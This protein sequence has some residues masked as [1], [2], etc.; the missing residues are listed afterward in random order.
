MNLRKIEARLAAEAFYEAV[1]RRIAM[2]FPTQDAMEKYLKEHP[3]ADKSRHHVKTNKAGPAIAD[4]SI[5]DSIESVMQEAEKSYQ[6]EEDKVNEATS[7]IKEHTSDIIASVPDFPMD[8][9]KILT[10]PLGTAVDDDDDTS[11]DDDDEETDE[12]ETKTKEKKP[13]EPEE[14]KKKRL[15]AA[16]KV[17]EHVSAIIKDKPFVQTIADRYSLKPSVVV[18]AI[19]G[20]YATGGGSDTRVDLDLRLQNKAKKVMRDRI[21][22]ESRE[23]GIIPEKLLAF[24]PKHLGFKID[25][26]HHT[27][28]VEHFGN[29]KKT[30]L[31]KIEESRLVLLHRN[32]IMSRVAEDLKSP[33]E[34]TRMTAFIVRMGVMTG[35]R[36]GTKGNKVTHTDRETGKKTTEQTYGATTLR[37]KHI[38]AMK[39]GIATISFKGKKGTVNTGEI[40]DAE[41]VRHLQS[42]LEGKNSNDYVFTTKKRRTVKNS[43]VNAYV[44]PY[45]ITYTDFRKMRATREVFEKLRD[46]SEKLYA[47]IA[48]A[49]DAN[50]EK[51]QKKVVA[52]IMAHLQKIFAQAQKS[53]SHE[54]V[55]TTINSYVNPMVVMNFLSTGKVYDELEEAVE[56][57]DEISFNLDAIIAEAQKHVRKAA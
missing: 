18:S 27:K 54:N 47:D 9:R 25:N 4:K 6:T 13:E 5:R 34:K 38:K 52:A 41:M 29:K 26:D 56:K 32:E 55:Q 44:Q 53:L 45:G 30:M 51:T 23:V 31:A 33:D 37:K 50:R 7:G 11:S 39:D 3:A 16:A 14:V 40:D 15:A 19:A 57:N 36:T 1:A 2:V 35:F 48:K 22:A 42:F 46:D 43:D 12:E 21:I 8:L 24:I 28:L 20:F 10:P 49:Q 17:K